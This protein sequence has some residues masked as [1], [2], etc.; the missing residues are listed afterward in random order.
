MNQQSDEEE[1]PDRPACRAQAREWLGG[2]EIP[3][4]PPRATPHLHVEKRPYPTCSDRPFSHM[5]APQHAC[6]PASALK[7]A[8]VPQFRPE[9]ALPKPGREDQIDLVDPWY[10]GKHEFELA[11]D[12]IEEV[13]RTSSIG[14][15]EVS[16]RNRLRSML[17]VSAGSTTA[18]L[19]LSLLPCGATSC[20]RVRYRSYLLLHLRCW[21]EGKREGETNESG[22]W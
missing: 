13:A 21:R 5:C 14:W 1:P 16:C 9:F 10:G 19:H 3:V 22:A 17:C 6:W 12:Q 20:V 2:D 4:G 15:H 7:C 11:I 18:G 8:H